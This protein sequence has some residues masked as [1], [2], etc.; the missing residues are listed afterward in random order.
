MSLSRLLDEPIPLT[1]DSLRLLFTT[2][3]V[4][5]GF[6]MKRS[7]AVARDRK[8][9]LFKFF[10]NYFRYG[11]PL[12]DNEQISATH[13]VQ[14]KKNPVHWLQGFSS[15]E[16]EIVLCFFYFRKYIDKNFSAAMFQTKGL[17]KLKVSNVIAVQKNSFREMIDIHK[18]IKGYIK[19]LNTDHQVQTTSYEF[20]D[21]LKNR[22]LNFLFKSCYELYLIS[23]EKGPDEN[24]FNHRPLSFYIQ[25]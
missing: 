15:E 7:K 21:Y 25:T 19:E 12:Y 17:E 20:E 13:Q 23:Y 24:V 14:Y 18:S 10:N 22:D 2:H 1:P 9:N 8:K 3:L 4:T 11:F 5:D 16:V 6:F